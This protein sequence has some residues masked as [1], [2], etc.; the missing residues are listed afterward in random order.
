MKLS[1][2]NKREKNNLKT[3]KQTRSSVKWYQR[4]HIYVIKA[5]GK[6]KEIGEKMNI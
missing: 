6:D 2:L 1:N 3:R 4:D 5:P